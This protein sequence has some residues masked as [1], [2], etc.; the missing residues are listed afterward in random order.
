[1]TSAAKLIEMTIDANPAAG[2]DVEVVYALPGH[3]WSFRLHLPA[4]STVADALGAANE[5]LTEAGVAI[6]PDRLAVY[7][8]PVTLDTPLR[9]GDRLELLRPLSTDPKQ[10]RRDRALGSLRQ[11]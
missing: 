8:R 11:P 7:S 3:Y 9:D 5:G 10:A 6:D 4:G 1:M 2:F